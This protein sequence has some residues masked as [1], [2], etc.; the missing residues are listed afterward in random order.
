MN[1]QVHTRIDDAQLNQY[2]LAGTMIRI[3][4]DANSENDVRGIVVAWDERVVLIRKRGSKNVVQLDRNY[5]YQPYDEP[6]KF[7]P[8]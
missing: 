7:P 4:R 8:L 5:I 3:V 1:E 2:R 6:R